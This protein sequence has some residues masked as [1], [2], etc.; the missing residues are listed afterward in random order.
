MGKR[1]RRPE[2]ACE[3]SSVLFCL[4]WGPASTRVRLQPPP[5]SLEGLSRSFKVDRKQLECCHGKLTS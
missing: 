5:L 4:P 3:A 1:G 2:A